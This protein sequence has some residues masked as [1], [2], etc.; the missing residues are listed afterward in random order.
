MTRIMMHLGGE[1]RPLSMGGNFTALPTD[2][3]AAWWSGLPIERHRMEPWEGDAEVGPLAGEQ[4]VVLYASGAVEIHTTSGG[5]DVTRRVVAGSVRVQSGNDR[6]RLR[7]ISG[8]ADVVVVHLPTEWITRAL[9]EK[10]VELFSRTLS[11]PDGGTLAALAHEMLT[12]VNRRGTTGRLFAESLSL[13]FVS[14]A[15]ARLSE[16]ALDQQAKR[17][18]FSRAESERLREFISSR[19]RDELSLTELASVV[20]LRPRHFSVL[21]HRAFG[22]SPYRFVLNRRLCE[23]ARLLATTELDVAEVAYEMGFCSQSHF[24]AMF[25]RAYGVTPGQYVTHRRSAV[26]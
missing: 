6:Q 3:R 18:A 7:R 9:G 19:F 25:R 26:S 22:C 23:A 14:H 20:G 13:A 11:L 15:G 8:S 12:E 10:G 5:R 2:G 1:N 4:G 16:R 17:R 24:T 21:F